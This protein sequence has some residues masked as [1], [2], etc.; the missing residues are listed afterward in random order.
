MEIIDNLLN[1]FTMYRV[2]LYSLLLLLIAG[3]TFSILGQIGISPLGLVINL[4]LLMVFGYTSNLIFSK[5]KRVSINFESGLISALI[6]ALILPTSSSISHYLAVVLTV[7]IA[8][9]G[10]FFITYKKSVIFNPAALAAVIVSIT[11][12]LPATWW[13]GSPPLAAFT[14]ITGF[15]ILRKQRNF[16]LFFSYAV[17]SYFV[18]LLVN[19]ISGDQNAFGVLKTLCLRYPLLFM[20]SVMLSEPSTLPSG[21]YYQI[22]YGSIVGCIFTSQLPL[23]ILSSTP[24]VALVIGNIFAFFVTNRFSAI[25][26]FRHRREVAPGI[27]EFSF[28]LPDRPIKFT[29]GQYLEWTLPVDKIDG[30]GNRRT[31]TLAS[32]PTESELIFAT[33]IDSLKTNFKNELMNI[34][35]GSTIRASQLRGDFTLPLDKDKPIILIAGGIGITP[36]R[37]MVKYLIDTSEKRNIHLLYQAGKQT[38]FIYKDIFEQGRAIGLNTDYLVGR[39]SDSVLRQALAD[40]Q[41]PK[42]YISGPNSM[43][44]SYK[45][46]LNSLGLSDNQ[47]KID[48]FSGY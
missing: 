23:G 22:L 25:L 40:K 48:Y 44:R 20:G 36:F 21:R 33:R 9:A 4:I 10:K 35:D 27:Y 5:I 32:S 8:N 7:V 38:D 11:S 39:L 2:V 42:I 15:L 26:A 3:F 24:E 19:H 46:M 18:F 29:A 45:K 31:F 41:S 28:S 17:A 12:I 47:I 1:R 16:S 13:I 14:A 34:K 30:R 43:V 6:L 37:S